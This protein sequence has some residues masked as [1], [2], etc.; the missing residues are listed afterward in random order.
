MKKFMKVILREIKKKDNK[1]IADLIRSVF[2][3]FKINQAG[4]VYSDPTTDDLYSLFRTPGSIYWIAEE[5][6]KIIGGC[7]I[8]PTMGL[9]EGC[10]EL[11]KL[12]L[13][14][15]HRGKGT[16]LQLLERCIESARNLGYRQL[17]LESFPE[18]S[19]AI[20]LYER[21]G[22]RFIPGAIGNSGH[23]SC[24]I[25]MLKDI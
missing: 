11:V 23:T 20:R 3:E 16:G 9:P 21:A 25:W 18:L 5:D 8:F 17:Y 10:A 2:V 13:L 19:K 7:G 12:Y 24:N 1:E 6:R 22:F 14:S 15:K 4:T